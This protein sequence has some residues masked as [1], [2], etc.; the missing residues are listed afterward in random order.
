LA[1]ADNGLSVDGTGVIVLGQDIGAVGDPAQ[2]L[3]PREIP[4]NGFSLNIRDALGNSYLLLDNTNFQ[5]F[6]TAVDGLGNA[7]NLL[8]TAVGGGQWNLIAQGA[9]STITETGDSINRLFSVKE[10]SNSFL[11]LDFVNGLYEIGDISGAGN[12]AFLRVD[13]AGTQ[14]IQALANGAFRYEDT[15]G[16]SFFIADAS[17]GMTGGDISNL[18]AGAGSQF[19]VFGGSRRLAFTINNFT[20]FLFEID[21][22]AGSYRLGDRDGIFNG[23]FLDIDDNAS[24]FKVTNS[25]LNATMVINGVLGFTGTVSPVTSITVNGGIVTNVT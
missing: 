22:S 2:L 24:Q 10:G 23:N 12:G 13:D 14:E 3:S 11:L 1:S 9:A 20:N 25:A 8:L 21:A 5:S 7:S 4:L 6:V 15:A 17:G 18:F 16:N 19:Q